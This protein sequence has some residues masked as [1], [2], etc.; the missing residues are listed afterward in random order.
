MEEA[1]LLLLRHGAHLGIKNNLG[2]TA[3]KRIL[4]STLE[5]FLDSCVH[6]QDE[7]V[8]SHDFSVTFDYAFLAPPRVPTPAPSQLQ[9]S[10]TGITFNNQSDA[11]ETVTLHAQSGFILVPRY[12]ILNL[13]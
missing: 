10:E 5:S 12:F 6:L 8:S 1:V 3:V 4:P 7:E 2:E 11:V 13:T 9:P